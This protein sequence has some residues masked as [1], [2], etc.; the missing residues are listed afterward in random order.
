AQRARGWETIQL[1]SPKQGRTGLLVEDIEGWRFYRT[2]TP[3]LSSSMFRLAELCLL[4]RATL[5]RLNELI[6]SER[7]NIIQPHSPVL[8]AFPALAAGRRHKLPVVYEM[9]ATWEDAAVDHG[10]ARVRSLRY[11]ASRGLETVAM[12]RVNAVTTICEGLREEIIERGIAPKK[13]T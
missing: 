2:P 8:N 4:M 5:V 1:T 10:T 9:R 7:P 3:R 6:T 11:L 13:V 12:K